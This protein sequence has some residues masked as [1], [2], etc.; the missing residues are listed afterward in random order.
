[1]AAERLPVYQFSASRRLR[2]EVYQGESGVRIS[3]LHSA[4]PLDI[5]RGVIELVSKKTGKVHKSAPIEL[6]Y[7]G[8]FASPDEKLIW[9]K[10]GKE[11]ARR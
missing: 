3:Q 4:I 1:M 2:G 6:P 8:A 5:N 7:G 10:A 11:L 9:E